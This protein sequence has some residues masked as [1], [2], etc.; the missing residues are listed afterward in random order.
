MS[1]S[2]IF[3]E[4]NKGYLQLENIKCSEMDVNFEKRLLRPTNANIISTNGLPRASRNLFGASAGSV[5]GGGTNSSSIHS[6]TRNISPGS[7][8]CCKLM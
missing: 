7:S 8:V 3:S 4:E 1:F 6:P 5:V 2:S